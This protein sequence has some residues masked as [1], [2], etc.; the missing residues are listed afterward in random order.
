[1]R[2]SHMGTNSWVVH[3]RVRS[4]VSTYTIRQFFDIELDSAQYLNEPINVS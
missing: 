4:E 1:M 2:A 3:K